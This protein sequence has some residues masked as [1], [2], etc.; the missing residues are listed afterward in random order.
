LAD[1]L[2]QNPYQVNILLGGFDKEGP[3][4]YFLDYLASMHKVPFGAHGYAGYFIYGLLDKLYKDGLSLDEGVEVA[5]ACVKELQTRMVLNS[6]KY[7][8]KIVDSTGTRV[9][10]L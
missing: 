7:L 10:E 3:S 4:L 1:A 2:R 8:A 5:R 9:I 6:P